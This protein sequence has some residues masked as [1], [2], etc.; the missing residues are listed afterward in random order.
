MKG[1]CFDDDHAE[2]SSKSGLEVSS[3]IA[4]AN[5]ARLLGRSIALSLVVAH[6]RRNRSTQKV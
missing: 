2:F 4:C 1:F 5:E 3:C 6:T